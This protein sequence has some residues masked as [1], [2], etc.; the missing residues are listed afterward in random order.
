L[1]EKRH[2]G[3]TRREAFEALK[4]SI[5]DSEMRKKLEMNN[6]EAA[7]NGWD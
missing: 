7:A 1:D 3:I 4:E 6:E 2:D 5:N